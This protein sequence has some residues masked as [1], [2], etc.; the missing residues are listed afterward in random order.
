M[1]NDLESYVLD[2]IISIEKEKLLYFMLAE[3]N[4]QKVVVVRTPNILINKDTTGQQKFLGY[5]W[6]N[7]KGNEGIKYLNIVTTKP[8]D[9]EEID[10][11]IQQL[12]GIDGVKT[13]LFNPQDLYDTEKIN[14]LIRRNYTEDISVI[15][16]SLK[17]YV[18]LFKLTDMLDFKQVNFEKKLTEKTIEIVSKYPLVKLGDIAEVL[19]GKSIT[20]AQAKAGNVKVVAGGIDYAYTHNESNR[21]ANTI[22]VSASGANAGYVNFWREPIFASDCTTIRGRNDTHTQFLYN[23]LLSI[24]NQIYSLQNGAGVPHVHPSDL[25]LIN[26]PNIDENLQREIVSECEKVDEEYNNSRMCIE[27]WKKKIAEVMREVNGNQKTIAEIGKICMCKRIL[28][29]ETNSDSGIPFYKIGTFGGHANTYIPNEL[30]EKYR[31]QYPYPQ[32]GQILISAAGTLGKSVVFDGKPA[33]FQDSNI[34]WIDNDEKIVFNQ[35]LFRV[36]QVVKW[37]DYATKGSVIPR[38]YNDKLRSV[39]IP[40]PSLSEQQ[41]IVSEIETYEQKIAEAKAV[42]AGCAERKK[43]ILDKWLK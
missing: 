23:F 38:I 39:T 26:I 27:E 12:K 3:S 21:P 40:V 7:S 31:T 10:D 34:V 43:Q 37:E 29:K 28:K 6:S 18:S 41:R 8:K 16:E 24:Q 30:Y 20:S 36:L 22:T 2:S 32:K 1:N 11:T 33:Y 17:D 13:P 15:P 4:R 35:F 5:K 19:K 42:M 14:T 25:K 9:G